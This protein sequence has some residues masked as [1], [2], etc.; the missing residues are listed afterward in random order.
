[1]NVADNS[2]RDDN[3]IIARNYAERDSELDGKTIQILCAVDTTLGN[4]LRQQDYLRLYNV[5]V[6]RQN[7][8]LPALYLRLLPSLAS[9]RLLRLR[10][11]GSA[12]PTHQFLSPTTHRHVPYQLR[13]CTH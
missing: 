5:D 4:W 2:K 13:H 9:I 8:Y 6:Q 10:C 3:I 7:L 11:Q 12:L 1:V